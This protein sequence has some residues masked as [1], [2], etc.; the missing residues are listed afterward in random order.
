MITTAD[1]IWITLI[2]KRME[3]CEQ[4]ARARRDLAVKI[5]RTPRYQCPTDYDKALAFDLLGVIC[6]AAAVLYLS[7]CIWHFG[8]KEDI[9]NHPDINDNIDVKGCS[10]H[11]YQLTIAP[12]GRRDWIY[13]LATAP[14]PPI[15]CLRGWCFGR[16]GM[17]KEYDGTDK[18]VRGWDCFWIP[19]TAPVLRP[20]RELRI[21]L[22]GRGAR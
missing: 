9:R 20:M 11:G 14:Q 18:P 8:P 7:P 19:Q 16:D 15:V 12:D 6:E 2:A 10:G 17:I 5:G 21:H 4:A 1:L 3:F 22:H 13:V